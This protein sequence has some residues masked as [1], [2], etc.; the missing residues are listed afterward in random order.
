[1][2]S[3]MALVVHALIAVALIVAYV[4]VTITEHDGTPLLTLTAGYLL[5]VGAQAGLR[6]A[7]AP[8]PP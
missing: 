3:G 6:R 7:G 8:P 1:M 2:A 5:G 4:I